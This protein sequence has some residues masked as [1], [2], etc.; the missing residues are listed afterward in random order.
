MGLSLA[1]DDGSS[2]V[3]INYYGLGFF[4]IFYFLT[5]IH[6]FSM[7]FF[8]TS[9]HFLFSIFYF[10]TFIHPFSTLFFLASVHFL[11]SRRE[12]NA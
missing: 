1:S 7:S 6:P 9:V 12:K 4:S 11:F 5:F 10:L 8:L 2:G 3:L